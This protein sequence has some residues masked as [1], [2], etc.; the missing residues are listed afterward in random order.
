MGKRR[1]GVEG[2]RTQ[3]VDGKQLINTEVDQD[4]LWAIVNEDVSF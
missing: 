2:S 3:G 4:V 1:R